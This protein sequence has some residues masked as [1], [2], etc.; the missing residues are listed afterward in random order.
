MLFI[1]DDNVMKEELRKFL[2]SNLLED[3][4]LGVLSETDN[5]KVELYLSKYPEA[6]QKYNQMQVDIEIMAKKTAIKAPTAL[7]ASIMENIDAHSTHTTEAN[8]PNS[9]R[10]IEDSKTR[11]S[12]WTMAASFAALCFATTAF[13]LWN[14]NNN[15]KSQLASAETELIRVK[16]LNQDQESQRVILASNLEIIHNAN[17]ERF[18]LSGNDKAPQFSTVAYWNTKNRKGYLKVNE[19]PALPQNR[20]FQLWADVDGK[21]VSLGVIQNK[22]GLIE[23]PFKEK[24]ESLNITIEQEG[25]SDH[26][27]VSQLVASRVI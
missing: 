6:Q 25:G 20:C 7:K 16:A 2:E 19:L 11:I 24:A 5:Q 1:H 26:P 21:M 17:T 15:L 27:D 23:L 22:E 13:Y 10:K 9:G 4:L 14:Q 3:Y 8:L 18:V 12:W